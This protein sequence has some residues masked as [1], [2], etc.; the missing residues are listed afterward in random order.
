MVKFPIYLDLSDKRVILIGK[1]PVV[2]RLI[3]ELYQAG[4]RIVVIAEN[5]TPTF[6]LLCERNGVELILAA[7]SKD[8][9]AEAA[10]AIAA[11]IDSELNERIYKDCQQLEVLCHRTDATEQCD[12]SIPS[13]VKCGK[14]QIA[15][16]AEGSPAYSGH[17][18]RKLE[19][20]FSDEHSRFLEELET[21]RKHIIADIPSP[22]DQKSVL[23]HLVGDES[24]DYFLK[25]GPEAW[26]NRCRELFRHKIREISE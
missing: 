16:N 14:L 26:R 23:G 12:F 2:C 1:G 10:L 18:C 17:I 8:Y 25:Q 20:T 5:P 7:Y 9:L 11:T 21:A 6:I 19:M 22:Q 13:V 4:A 15:V 3:P 24:F